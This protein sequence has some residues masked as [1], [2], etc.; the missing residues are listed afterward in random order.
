MGLWRVPALRAGGAYSGEKMYQVDALYVMPD[1]PYPGIVSEYWDELRDARTWSYSGRPAVLHPPCK[2]WGR[3]WYADGSG[4]PGND[5]GLFS[6]A[7]G[8]LLI[9]GGVLEHPQASHAWARFSI[10]RPR[11]GLWI[12]PDNR[13]IYTTE[14]DQILYGHKARKRTWLLYKGNR[15]PPPLNWS[16]PP[17]QKYYLCKPGRTKDRPGRD[18]P[19]LTKAEN[20]RTPIAF[21]ELMCELATYSGQ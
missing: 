19:T 3:W 10:A 9:A 7:L 18:V 13:G 11:R 1:G 16:D 2:R 6:H 15:H 14:V 4:A 8:V 12:G 17:K 20:M 21:A 5:G